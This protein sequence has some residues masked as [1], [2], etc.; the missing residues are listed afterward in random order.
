MAMEP[1]VRRHWPHALVTWSRLVA[2]GRLRDP[3]V[4]RDILVGGAAC[5]TWILICSIPLREWIG[6]TSPSPSS[7]I[8]ELTAL[9]GVRRLLGVHAGALLFVLL[10]PMV[11]FF[12]V[13]LLRMVLRRAWLASLMVL[14]LV[15]LQRTVTSEGD[16]VA[17]LHT[18]L[19][20]ATMLFVLVRFGLLAGVF[21]NTF[22]VFPSRLPPPA[23]L[24]SW[25]TV[26]SITPLVL[27]GVLAVW[28]FIV[29]RAG[30]PIL[31][32]FLG[33]DPV[34]ETQSPGGIR[35]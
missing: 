24:S 7:A 29:S 25:Y 27:L 23:D 3:L 30:R 32:G 18:I 31:D 19:F 4:G 26:Y 34:R 14:A 22:L 16:P 2:L 13:L 33:E 15:V 8:W 11:L 20:F 10:L 28:G 21:M 9:E 6:R 17:V 12:M 1:Y 35:R 5:V